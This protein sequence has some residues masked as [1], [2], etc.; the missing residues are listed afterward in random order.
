MTWYAVTDTKGKLLSLTTAKPDLPKGLKSVELGDEKPDFSKLK[1]NP[2][3][4]KMVP[5]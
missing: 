1:W 5:K 3:T 2:K 4:S